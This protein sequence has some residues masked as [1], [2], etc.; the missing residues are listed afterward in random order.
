MRYCF[1]P[2]YFT[3]NSRLFLGVVNLSRLFLGVEKLKDFFHMTSI[4]H[5]NFSNS[6]KSWLQHRKKKEIS[7][8]WAT[9]F[10]LFWMCL[11]FRTSQKR[12]RVVEDFSSEEERRPVRKRKIEN[13]GRRRSPSCS[14]DSEELQES[15]YFKPLEE[16]S[17]ASETT[18][19]TSSKNKEVVF[20][21][22]RI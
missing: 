20:F 2:F 15:K 3:E 14:L 13:S 7:K 1:C 9:M 10:I 16:R 6:T 19:G 18:N 4:C 11:V 12:K 17:L 21:Q 8:L 22:R 5:V